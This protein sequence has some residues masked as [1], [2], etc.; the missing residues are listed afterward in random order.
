MS[1]QSRFVMAIALAMHRVQHT[2]IVDDLTHIREQFTDPASA[3]TILFET[4]S[5]LDQETVELSRFIE[6]SRSR[7]GLAM[8][9]D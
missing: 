5:W 2:N 9:G 1:S 7:D 4:K 8:I 3:L 6:P